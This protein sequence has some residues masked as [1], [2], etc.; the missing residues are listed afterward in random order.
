MTTT[1]TQLPVNSELYAFVILD[2]DG[3]TYQLSIGRDI[4]GLQSAGAAM[5]V[6]NFHSCE[7]AK[8]FAV[9]RGVLPSEIFCHIA[10]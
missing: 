7:D 10:K 3:T 4:A 8:Q 6:G 9:L 5:A 2:T 1:T